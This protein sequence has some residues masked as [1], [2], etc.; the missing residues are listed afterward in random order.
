MPDEMFAEEQNSVD[1]WTSLHDGVLEAVRSDLS[2]RTISFVIASPFHWEFHHLQA[3]TRFEV[4]ANGARFV[5]AFKFTPWPEATE[6]PREAPWEEAQE[7]RRLDALKGRLISV[8]WEDFVKQ[9]GTDEEYI[10]MSAELFNE[11]HYSRLRLGALGYPSSEFRDLEIRAE[12][13]SFLVGGKEL[14]LKEF[15]Q[16]GDAYWNDWASRNKTDSKES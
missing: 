16:F 3:D 11:E 5:T 12:A 2:S 9:I 15:V 7:Q 6:P 10:I 14:T 8:N 1:L 13:F 4:I